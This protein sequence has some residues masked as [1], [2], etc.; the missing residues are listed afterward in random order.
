MNRRE[1][2]RSLAGACSALALNSPANLS[3]AASRG[4]TRLGIVTYCLGI[5]Q[6]AMAKGGAGKSL[7]DP[8]TFLEE[9]HALGA[10][11]VQTDLGIHDETYTTQLRRRAEGLDMHVEGVIELPYVEADLPRF[12]KQVQTAARA[13]ATVARATLM[14][15]RRYEQFTSVKD[16][17]AA[18]AR[19]LKALQLAEPL[20]ARRRFGLALEN[21]KDQR[22]AERL[23]LLK[24]LSSQY[25]GACVDV[26]NDL[27]LLEDPIEVVRAY[28]PW[29]FTAHLKDHAVK[30]CADGFLLADTALGEGFLE[31]PAMLDILRQAKP[32]LRFNLEVITRDPL[33]VPVL[34][35]N[36][37]ATLADVPASD[38]ARTLRLVKAK[39]SVKPL[40]YVTKLSPEQ[41][42]EEETG[43]ILRS[44]AYARERLR[45]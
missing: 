40:T 11:G 21:H 43:N 2:L 22:V 7:S 15:G 31:L 24:R 29:A 32:G 30:E 18:V 37:W 42:V 4:T 13:G 44:L 25:V 9:C 23:E 26:G 5:R 10:G 19:G 12:E 8:L 41:Q 6:K 1:M 35:D 27:A 36:Y 45:L 28:A 16:Y 20:L 38:L 39:S 14:P 33:K 17:Q 34:T 3:A